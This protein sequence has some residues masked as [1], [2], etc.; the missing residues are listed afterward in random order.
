MTKH[1]GSAPSEII[2][3]VT[4]DS[5]PITATSEKSTLLRNEKYRRLLIGIYISLLY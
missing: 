3:L 5:C 4:L 1:A 2:F